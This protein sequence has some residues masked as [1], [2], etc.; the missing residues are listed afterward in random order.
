[1]RMWAAGHTRER[2]VSAS[3]PERPSTSVSTHP[4]RLTRTFSPVPAPAG[5]PCSSFNALLLPDPDTPACRTQS[6]TP[7]QDWNSPDINALLSNLFGAGGPPPTA[8]TPSSAAG[9]G[10]GGIGQQA[11][12]SGLSH[13]YS[14]IGM[15]TASSSTAVTG[16]GSGG[17]IFQPSLVGSGLRSLSPDEASDHSGSSSS[18]EASTTKK[19]ASGSSRTATKRKSKASA[20]GGG[21]AGSHG[22][23]GVEGKKG[24]TASS[25]GSTRPG[26]LGEDDDEGKTG[27][28]SSGE[29]KVRSTAV[30]TTSC[31]LAPV[32]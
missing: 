31:R 22:P 14:G 13:S 3:P 11:S 9:G 21:A 2:A 10:G 1:M 4:A 20:S 12:S 28:K 18:D 5:S 30:C 17:S 15:P 7:R 23:T 27:R 16:G 24:R 26:A 32:C 25:S 29:P 19:K 6:A 8:S